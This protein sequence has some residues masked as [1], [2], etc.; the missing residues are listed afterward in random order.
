MANR[1]INLGSLNISDSNLPKDY[2]GSQKGG[3]QDQS[4]EESLVYAVLDYVSTSEGRD[5]FVQDISDQLLL[6][7]STN[8]GEMLGSA[9]RALC[10]VGHCLIAGTTSGEV[11]TLKL[12]E[13]YGL[14]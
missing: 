11:S 3:N 8:W 13:N 2:G 5:Q 14:K 1:G 6:K 7:K 12:P 4:D 10:F 9:P